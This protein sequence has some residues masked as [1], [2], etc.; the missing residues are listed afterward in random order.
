MR[1]GNAGERAHVLAAAYEEGVRHFDVAPIY[2][3]G[4]AEG[5]LGKFLLGRRDQVTLAT[6]FGIYPS[7]LARA[8]NPIQGFLRGIFKISPISRRLARVG[9]MALMNPKRFDVG[10]AMQSLRRSLR[11]LRTDYVD[12]F[13][14]HEPGPKDFIDPAL[15]PAILEQVERG[16]IRNIGIAGS[17]EHSGSI[18]ERYAEF[19]QVVQIENDVLGAQVQEIDLSDVPLIITYGAIERPLVYLRGF[20]E[21]QRAITRE[22]SLDL[23][24]DIDDPEI[25]PRLL[26]GYAIES[27]AAGIVLFSSTQV[28][29]VRQVVKWFHGHAEYAPKVAR[30]VELARQGHSISHSVVLE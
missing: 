10:S 4:S 19:R 20:L 26:F 16:A 14:L 8:L 22:W 25:L 21:R 12:V 27:N 18:I 23:D 5:E 6:K 28:A 3:M 30:F 9:G 29:H 11:E 2:G 24:I 17:V 1:L 7:P 15:L 13:F